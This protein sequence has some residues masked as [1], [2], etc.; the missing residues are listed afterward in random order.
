MREQKGVDLSSGVNFANLLEYVAEW[1][2]GNPDKT[3]DTSG[4]GWD[5]LSDVANDGFTVTIKFE[6]QTTTVK[7]PVAAGVTAQ[8][9]D[10]N[11]GTRTDGDDVSTDTQPSTGTDTTQ[12]VGENTAPVDQA[13]GAEAPAEPQ[14]TETNVTNLIPSVSIAPAAA[15]GA[16]T[17][18]SPNV[19]DTW[20]ASG[21][22]NADGV[23]STA[24]TPLRKLL[25]QRMILN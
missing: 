19:F 17:P 1:N 4:D 16:A 3:I 24:L 7:V 20:F 14:Y 11:N 8:T 25:G 6:A 13:T 10:N 12:P 15:D 23:T 22:S 2:K 21:T 5:A 9:N 18:A